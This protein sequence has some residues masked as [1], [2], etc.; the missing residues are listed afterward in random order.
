M[1]LK[2]TGKALSCWL[3]IATLL[4]LVGVACAEE[5]E[6]EEE[7]KVDMTNNLHKVSYAMGYKIGDMFQNLKLA[8]IPDAVMKGMFDARKNI[9]PALTKAE[10]KIILRDPKKFLAE[11]IDSV[12]QKNKK[13]GELFLAANAKRPNVVVL[14]S[15]LQY[16]VLREGSGRTPEHDD[17]VK[18]HYKGRNLKG[19]V[20]DDT[21]AKGAPG[22]LAVYS[23]LP[24]M[25]EALQL[26]QEGAKWEIYV[27]YALAYANFG[28]MAGQTLIFEVELLEVL[29]EKE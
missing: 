22:E 23:V 3:A 7:A 5:M 11:D 19:H 16:S 27:P 8:I 15:G 28:P 1:I 12:S 6:K 14:D 25:A 18:V 26:M 24:G 20:F 21:Y 4:I 9:R 13:E 17:M 2:Q 29:P 10:M